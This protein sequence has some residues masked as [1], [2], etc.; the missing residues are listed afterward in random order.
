MLSVAKNL[1][2]HRGTRCFVALSLRSVL[3]LS[4]TQLRLLLIRPARYSSTNPV[5]WQTYS[6]SMDIPS[7][8]RY[9]YARLRIDQR[10]PLTVSQLMTQPE[11]SRTVK[12][13]L[14]VHSQYSKDSL[15]TLE[16]IIA[17]CR[18]KGLD[19]I[20]LTDHNAIEG[21]L[22]LRDMSPL[23][24]IVGQEITT[25]WGEIIAYF[26]E[27]LIPAGLHPL[28]AVQRV[29]E[30]GG[31]VSIPHPLDRIRREA[32]GRE[33]VLQIIEHVDALEVF[34]SRCLLPGFNDAARALAH[35]Y[36]LPGTA[37][38]DAHSLVEI[39]V[40]YLEM[41]AF[42]SKDEF[43]QNLIQAEIHGRPSLPLVHLSSTLSKG[44]KRWRRWRN[45]PIPQTGSA[46]S[47]GADR[48]SRP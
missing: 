34:N 19:V 25:L 36:G 3:R 46:P 6:L 47:H 18:R 26:V 12:V 10:I 32:M 40:T 48:S 23:P 33:K 17:T 15:N 5:E 13:D 39:G 42:H 1:F 7:H 43:L 29:R 30:Q 20:C 31:L 37:G 45:R 21:A 9:T 41:A 24:V 8:L 4:M 28:E 16:D 2:I 14:H 35:E 11:Q 22:R 27:E 44:V 38:S